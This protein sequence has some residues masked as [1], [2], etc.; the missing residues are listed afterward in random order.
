MVFSSLPIEEI[1]GELMEALRVPSPRILLKAPTGSG[2]STGVPPMMDD[3]GL[4][5][6]GLIVVV[7]PRR[8]AARLLARHVARLRGVELG[9]EV[10]YAV[11]FERYISSRTRIAYVTD[12]MLERWLT[13][14]PSLEGVSAVVFDEFHER[15][16]S[17]D[18][19]LG[20]VLDLQEG[21]RRDLAVV[22]M[23]ATLRYQ[24]C[25]NI[26]E[27]PAGFWKRKAGSIPWKSFTG[28]P[29]WSVTDAAGWLLPPYGSR[30]RMLCGR[31]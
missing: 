13:E 30:R 12:G 8:M 5:D 2:K 25:G 10:G 1:R 4:G 11:R 29:A 14:R 6:R 17:G 22:V 15:S 9:K 31:R 28:L 20:R 18:L 3:A 23:S 21:P 19:S 27:V 7:Q 24:G 26:W 16:L